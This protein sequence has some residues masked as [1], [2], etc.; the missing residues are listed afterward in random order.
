MDGAC[1]WCGGHERRLNKDAD[2]D[3]MCADELPFIP[4]D[5]HTDTAILRTSIVRLLPFIQGT[6]YLVI[7]MC[8]KEVGM[9]NFMRILQALSRN[10]TEK[11]AKEATSADPVKAPPPPV[12]DKPTQKRRNKRATAAFKPLLARQRSSHEIA[13]DPSWAPSQAVSLDG[14]SAENA[15]TGPSAAPTD[16]TGSHSISSLPAGLYDASTAGTD[17]EVP[18]PVEPS[19]PAEA[20]AMEPVAAVTPDTVD[21]PVE[22][23]AGSARTTSGSVAGVAAAHSP[24]E[25]SAAEVAG[26]AEDDVAPPPEVPSQPPAPAVVA[27]LSRVPAD[28][29]PGDSRARQQPDPEG[30][31]IAEGCSLEGSNIGDRGGPSR[32]SSLSLSCLLADSQQEVDTSDDSEL[33][34]NGCC[35]GTLSCTQ[36]TCMRS[37]RAAMGEPLGE[38]V[39]PL[40]KEPLLSDERDRA[41]SP[42][43]LGELGRAMA[44]GEAPEHLSAVSGTSP[45]AS[46]AHGKPLQALQDALQ[47]MESGSP[48][49]TAERLGR[50]QLRAQEHAARVVTSNSLRSR[51]FKKLQLG[52]AR[53]R[54][55]GPAATSEGQKDSGGASEDIGPV[56]LKIVDPAKLQLTSEQLLEDAKQR[57]SVRHT[58]AMQVLVRQSHMRCMCHT[59]PPCRAGRKVYVCICR[60]RCWCPPQHHRVL[61]RR[62]L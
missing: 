59:E 39:N 6:Q 37:G 36:G 4:P 60:Q 12:S 3:Y 28:L 56:A 13:R 26:D 48:G 18:A 29:V 54:R 1:I 61:S 49:V 19:E 42:P 15:A 62:F 22:A 38:G 24:T 9:H 23:A 10:A 17:A 45:D 33:G 14:S 8:M 41:E 32:E 34:L 35:E 25:S 47:R 55:D 2:N 20:V 57:T 43:P 7:T 50:L 44:V 52:G 58:E 31:P 16:A 5:V 21:T 30:H 53:Q 11:A 46:T 27:D 40:Y 51:Q